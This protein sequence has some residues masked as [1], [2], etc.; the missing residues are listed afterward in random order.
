MV[1]G[2][3]QERKSGGKIES[4]KLEGKQTSEMRCEA[5]VAYVER[6]KLIS[7]S[8]ERLIVKLG[9]LLANGFEIHDRNSTFPSGS[10]TITAD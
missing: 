5:A 8:I 6:G 7:V 1:H 10:L 4:D 3:A 9:K 2:G